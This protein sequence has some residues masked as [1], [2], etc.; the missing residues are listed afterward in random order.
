MIS[1]GVS[2]VEALVVDGKKK[3]M[4]APVLISVLCW[5]ANILFVDLSS[6]GT[7]IVGFV[8]YP[9]ESTEGSRYV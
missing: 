6:S 3:K 9:R 4:G 1:R 2:A 8:L 5:G 7:P